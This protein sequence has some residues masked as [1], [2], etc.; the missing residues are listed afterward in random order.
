LI[1]QKRPEKGGVEVKVKE[2]TTFQVQVSILLKTIKQESETLN[3]RMVTQE[4]NINKNQP[5]CEDQDFKYRS[6]FSPKPS[7]GNLRH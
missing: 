7:R 3:D 4:N 5:S 1:V 2:K 6:L